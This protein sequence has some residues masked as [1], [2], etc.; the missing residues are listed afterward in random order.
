MRNVSR[1]RENRGSSKSRVIRSSTTWRATL[2]ERSLKRFITFTSVLCKF[3]LV[4][5][6]C[7]QVFIIECSTSCVASDLP[8]I[9]S[10]FRTVGVQ[11]R[12]CLCS[13]FIPNFARLPLSFQP[14]PPPNRKIK[15]NLY[16]TAIFLVHIL[17]KKMYIIGASETSFMSNM[18]HIKDNVLSII[19]RS[20]GRAC[21]IFHLRFGLPNFL[22]LTIFISHQNFCG[23][24]CFVHN[25]AKG[26][27]QR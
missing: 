19:R 9:T 14:L 27:T 13:I 6:L 7:C 23:M 5:F 17:Q 20:S 3:L 21:I 22:F 11:V 2:P 12:V 1:R 26:T 25:F 16:H 4:Q 15:K 18:P 8:D 24:Q 10:K